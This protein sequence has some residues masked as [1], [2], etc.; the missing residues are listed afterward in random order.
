MQGAAREDDQPEGDGS[1]QLFLGHLLRYPVLRQDQ[2]WAL[3]LHG[4]LAV[5]H[6]MLQDQ[7]M[8]AA[9]VG[10]RAA[11]RGVRDRQHGPGPHQLL[12]RSVRRHG[13][14]GPSGT[15]GCDLRELG[16]ARLHG[17]H[18]QQWS[19]HDLRDRGGVHHWKRVELGPEHTVG[20]HHRRHD[21]QVCSPGCLLHVRGPADIRGVDG[22]QRPADCWCAGLREHGDRVPG[23]RQHQRLQ[24]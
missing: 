22:E 15:L 13:S 2:R 19:V 10:F 5:L 11:V 3:S 4:R 6:E 20:Q 12:P 21:R 8:L 18:G 17:R 24:S 1:P 9:L 7:V 14:R 16:Q 23:L